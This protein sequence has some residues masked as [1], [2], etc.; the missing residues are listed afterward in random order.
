MAERRVIEDGEWSAS[1]GGSP[2]GAS[3]SPLLANVYLHYVLDRWVRQ[4]RRRHAHGDMIIVRFAD[5]FV[6]GF[7]HQADAKQF[8]SDLRE[9]FAK[10][11][12]ELHPDKTRLIE[13]GRYAA[14][15]REARG[16]GKPETFDFLGFTHFCG[17]TKSGRFWLRR[18][19]SRNGCGRSWPRSKTNSGDAA[20]SDSGARALAGQRGARASRLLRRAGQHRRGGGLPQPGDMALAQVASASQ[21]AQPSQLGT[22]EPHRQPVAPSCPC[23]SIPSRP[24]ASTPPPEAGAQC[25]SSARWDLCGGPPERAVPTAI[26][27]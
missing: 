27:K 18:R 22:D 9:R 16:V 17:K 11:S 6:V 19:P 23:R 1:D 14:R 5:D 7:E 2:Q 3:A 10:F 21:P 4:W 24:C 25:G 13:F 20:S 8:L 12:L 15:T 26:E